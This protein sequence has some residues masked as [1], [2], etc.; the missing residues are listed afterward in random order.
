M[1][2]LLLARTTALLSTDQSRA[3]PTTL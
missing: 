1:L 2:R 3:K